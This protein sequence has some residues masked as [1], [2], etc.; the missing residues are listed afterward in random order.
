[1]FKAKAFELKAT[2]M[3]DVLDADNGAHPGKKLDV[4]INNLPLAY[5]ITRTT[6]CN[7]PRQC[8]IALHLQK[9]QKYFRHT[10]LQNYNALEK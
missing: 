7:A 4:P 3:P 1:M 10:E 8:G 6:Q 9:S 2:Y 5:P